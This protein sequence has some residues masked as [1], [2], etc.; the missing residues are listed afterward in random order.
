M[1]V[2]AARPRWS[3]AVCGGAVLLAAL[4]GCGS[5][6]PGRPVPEAPWQLPEKLSAY[7]LF[8]GNGTT[9]EPAAGVL[10]YDINTPLFSDYAGKYRF[11]RLPPGTSSRYHETEVFDFPVG[12]VLVKTFACLHDL[13]D[14]ARGRQLIETRLL[15]RRPDGWIG[16]PYVWNEDQT[17]AT[18]RVA[19]GMRE[20]RWTHHDGRERSSLYL[21]PTQNQCHSCH[22]NQKVLRPIGPRAGHLN[23]DFAYAD[24]PEN[25]LIRWRRLGLLS[26]APA[27]E[28]APRTPVWNDPATGMLDQ[29]ARA[30]LEIN[31]A[32]CHNPDGPARSAGL[33]LRA[34]QADPRLWGVGKPPVA[35]GRGSG[36]WLYD[37]VPGK[38]DESI[39]VYRMESTE[40]GV[41]MPELGRRLV[42]EEGVALIREWIAG[43]SP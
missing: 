23:R 18:L 28:Q 16:L 17:E 10:P 13:R 22:E 20:I 32:H 26:G 1:G 36:G 21:I 40:I 38:P 7:G 6:R 34:L 12:T 41:L 42:D 8:L 37:I 35:A 43:L 25:Q 15:I 11:V 19:G 33:D 2:P 3:V 30:Y 14:P 39:L 31:C 29:R 4:A 24:G 9:Q 27:P 5:S